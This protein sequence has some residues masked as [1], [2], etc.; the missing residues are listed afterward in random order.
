MVL[1]RKPPVLIDANFS[2]LW[3]ND[4]PWTPESIV[5]V[6][7]SAWARACMEAIGTPMGGGALKLEATHLR[8]LPVPKLSSSEFERISEIARNGPKEP[9]LSAEGL[10]GIDIIIVK[11]ILG[12]RHDV[13]RIGHLISELHR[14]T[15]RFRQA[16]Q[17]R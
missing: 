5:G 8:R 9:H 6:L 13:G 7:N 16:R 15:D 14:L 10:N 12:G 1:N 2:T 17:R 4:K 3:A 11:G